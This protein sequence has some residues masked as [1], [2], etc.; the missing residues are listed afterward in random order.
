MPLS[1][2]LEPG[3]E[4]NQFGLDHWTSK[5]GLP[6]NSVQS[7]I[8]DQSGYLWLATQEGMV[9]F[10]GEEFTTFD[11]GDLPGLSTGGIELLAQTGDASIWVASMSGG[12]TRIRDGIVSPFEGPEVLRSSADLLALHTGLSG[13]LWIG[14]L[15]QGLYRWHPDSVERVETPKWLDA[16]GYLSLTESRDGSLWV[17]TNRG[18]KHYINGTWSDASLPPRLGLDDA[19]INALYEDPEGGLWIGSNAS[20]VRLIDGRATAFTPPGGRSWGTISA[21]V[22][23]R[24]GVLWVGTSPGGLFRLRDGE[25]EG[26]A[27]ESDL[28]KESIISLFEDRE[29]A[30]WAGSLAGGLFRVRDTPFDLTHLPEALPMGS[31]RSVLRTRDGTLWVGTDGSGL[32][33]REPGGTTLRR[34]VEELPSGVVQA[35]WERSDGALLIG[36]DRGLVEY[37]NGQIAALSTLAGL[38]QDPVRAVIEDRQGRIWVGRKTGG[39]VCIDGE[40]V[41]EYS[42][43]D[44]LP[45]TQIRWIEEDSKGRLWFATMRG[46][47]RFREGRFERIGLAGKLGDAFIMQIHEDGEGV[48]WISTYGQGLLRYEDGRL[49]HFGKEQGF[50]EA[51]IFGALEDSQGRLW[52]SCNT[53]VVGVRKTDIEAYRRGEISRIPT[54]LFTAKTG[55]PGTE[56]NG[57]S[58]PSVWKDTDGQLWFTTIAGLVTLDPE[59]VH[60][61]TD[62]PPV[63][64]SQVIVEHE[65]ISR[66]TW[67]AIPPGDRQ[68]E[69][70]YTGISLSSPGGHTFRYKMVGVDKDWV[71]AGERRV[72]YYTRVPPGRHTFIVQASRMEGDWSA[73]AASTTL[74]FEPYLYETHGFRALMILL[75]A[76]VVVAFVRTREG[77]LVRARLRLEELVQDKT[78]ELREAKE[79]ADEAN[80]CKSTFLANMSHEIRTPMNGIIGMSELVLDSELGPK[81]REGLE[82]VRSSAQSLLGLINDI[83]DLSKIEAD[84]LELSPMPFSLV[85]SIEDA[86]RTIAFRAEEK[87]IIFSCHIANEIPTRVIGDPSR[88]RQVILNLLGNAIKFTEA[89][90]VTLTVQMQEEHDGEP[91]VSFCIQD[92]GIG[93]SEEQQALVFDP[94]TQADA[95]ITRRFGGTGLGLAICARLARLLG[96]KITVESEP[97]VGSK[98][99]FTAKLPALDETIRVADL[100]DV[101]ELGGMR[102]L[103]VDSNLSNRGFLEKMLDGWGLEAQ[104]AGDCDRAIAMLEEGTRNGEPYRVALVVS[105]PPLIDS[106][107]LA[108]RFRQVS[109]G[110]V[111]PAVILLATFGEIGDAER[112]IESGV[113]AYLVHPF[114]RKELLEALREVVGTQQTHVAEK[115]LVTRHSLRERSRK[116]QVLV[117]EDNRV[118][119]AV[120]RKI[121]EHMGHTVTIVENGQLALDA[122]EQNRYDVVLM[123]VQMPVLDGL[124]AT[125]MIRERELTSPSRTPVI[126]LTANAMPGDRE[127]CLDAGADEYLSKPIDRSALEAA[128]ERVTEA[129]ELVLT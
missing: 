3:K 121:L 127:R 27:E 118:N 45:S 41:T 102:G 35:L 88:L 6:Q 97:G 64:I 84:R 122:L 79:A 101:K 111:A 76:L 1:L 113:D 57:G 85:D 12:L 21:F 26:W 40:K 55:F 100:A 110:S 10:D 72:A 120:A 43:K 83:L 31:T 61:K 86:V 117:A 33:Y 78:H 5:E 17:G 80:R 91:L 36:T 24:Q 70:H 48:L 51:R 65:A 112:C 59:Q 90:E 42:L 9:R 104:S 69:I 4:L 96:G 37:R 75:A 22:E 54:L 53:G 52:M 92:T 93:L 28:A 105:R 19:T 23:D 89:G 99:T 29:G 98:F 107:D 94:F 103:I 7:V 67:Q 77:R 87:G 73:T 119:Q 116:L 58:Q 39:L 63:E 124:A 71:D 128:I 62:P 47:A 49:E 108:K 30:L 123:D 95:S 74:V 16:L 46:L 126:A 38:S 13:Q 129:V 125:H 106:F 18:L 60:W 115:K 66:E 56:C 82:I 15:H 14:T 68:L 20:L 11:S 34:I 114:K 25:F 50:G 44:G 2:G 32:V 8:Q 109:G 81:Q